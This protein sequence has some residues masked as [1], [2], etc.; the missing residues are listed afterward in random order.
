E[1][2]NFG[3][4]KHDKPWYGALRCCAQT[5]VA[6]LPSQRCILHPAHFTEKLLSLKRLKY[7]QFDFLSY[8]I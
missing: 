7:K 1:A 8:I 5:P 3:H 2:Y 6:S 4:C